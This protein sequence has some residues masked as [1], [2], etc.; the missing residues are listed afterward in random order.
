MFFMA[1]NRMKVTQWPR[2]SRLQENMK[3]TPCFW[4]SSEDIPW[5]KKEN[6]QTSFKNERLPFNLSWSQMIK[7]INKKG[8]S[9]QNILDLKKNSKPASIAFYVFTNSASK[10]KEK[11]K[12]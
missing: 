1:G 10:K 7:N 8:V 4:A 6:I 9:L 12:K 2:Q 5:W 3:H 11:I